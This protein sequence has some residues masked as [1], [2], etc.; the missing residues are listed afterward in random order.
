MY[1]LVFTAI[2]ISIQLG[3]IILLYNLLSHGICVLIGIT[4]SEVIFAFVYYFFLKYLFMN[5]DKK[6]KN[7]DVVKTFNMDN[8]N[9]I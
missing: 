6:Y 9:E 4:L 5:F 7:K 2:K 8:I 1:S 3:L